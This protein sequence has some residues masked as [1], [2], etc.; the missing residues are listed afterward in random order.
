VGGLCLL[1]DDRGEKLDETL[2]PVCDTPG[3]RALHDRRVDPSS[4]AADLPPSVGDGL[5]AL[6]VNDHV[7]DVGGLDDTS[8]RGSGGLLVLRV[9]AE[10]AARPK[11]PGYGL[12]PFHELGRH[13]SAMLADTD[14]AV[15]DQTDG[16]DRNERPEDP[17]PEGGRRSHG[18]IT[19]VALARTLLG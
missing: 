11:L 6:A 17:E 18:C 9:D 14:Q 15:D 5:P 12:T 2:V 19:V 8:N 10:L 1:G 13:D 4:H 16:H 7:S 3:G